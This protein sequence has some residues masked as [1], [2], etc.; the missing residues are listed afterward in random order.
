MRKITVTFCICL[1]AATLGFSE[2]TARLSEMR[3]SKGVDPKLQSPIDV[4]ETF[5]SEPRPI[6]VTAKLLD[7]PKGTRVR[8]AVFYVEKG[9]QQIAA[10]DFPDI[11]GTG[12]FSFKL[13]PPASGWFLGSYKAFFYLNGKEH[14]SIGFAAVV[15]QGVAQQAPDQ[16]SYKTF[17]SREFGFSVQVPAGWV[18]GER[19]SK[20]VACMF[21]ANAQNSPV[22][23]LNVQAIPVTLADPSQFKSVINLVA[24]QLIDQILKKYKGQVKADNWAAAGENEGRELDSKYQHNGKIIRQ[25]QFLTYHAG[26]VFVVIY[27]VD[28]SIYDSYLNHYATAT[29]TLA[30]SGE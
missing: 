28:A 15:P 11:S 3:T 1:L 7:A 5:S 22:A 9:D 4:T 19:K 6:F 30:F 24:P 14:G 21:L 25:R 2:S 16:D 27:T 23:S 26:Y 12:Y 18:E 8:I 10:Y 29:K 17:S 20:S 13:N